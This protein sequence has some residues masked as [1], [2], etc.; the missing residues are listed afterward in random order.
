[1][2]ADPLYQSSVCY[3]FLDIDCAQCSGPHAHQGETGFKIFITLS[4]RRLIFFLST[5]RLHEAGGGVGDDD[6]DLKMIVLTA[7]AG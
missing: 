1:V 3:G 2:S 5:I 7:E 4:S 6:E